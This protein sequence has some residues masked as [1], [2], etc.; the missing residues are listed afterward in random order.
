MAIDG[1]ESGVV[2]RGLLAAA[3]AVL[4]NMRHVRRKKTC[5]ENEKGTHHLVG[6]GAAF[7]AAVALFASDR[8]ADREP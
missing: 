2:V 5:E 1:P 3:A 7:A 6:V 4:R 8:A